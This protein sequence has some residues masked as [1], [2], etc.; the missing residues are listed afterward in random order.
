ML[1]FDSF[2]FAL[3]VGQALAK[4]P[5]VVIK[6]R[7][8]TPHRSHVRVV[9]GPWSPSYVP[10]PRAGFVWVGWRLTAGLWSPGHWRPK[11]PPPRVG[12][13]F[14][15]GYWRSGVYVDGYWREPEQDGMVWVEGYYDDNGDWIE[16]R[17]V[18]EEDLDT[19]LASVKKTNRAVVLTWTPTWPVPQM[20][21]AGML[22]L[23]ASPCTGFRLNPKAKQNTPCPPSR[24]KLL[25]TPSP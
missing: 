9:L 23:Q 21:A 5:K 19:Y 15:P 1:G 8:R 22:T 3:F 7:H 17:W 6:H 11:A 10:A 4:P 16:G 20:R 2:I 18:A 13:V 12:L 14:V 24:K 25:D